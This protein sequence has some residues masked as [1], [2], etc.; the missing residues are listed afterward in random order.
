[1]INQIYEL[2]SQI[3]LGRITTYGRLAK[4][5]GKPKCSRWVGQIMKRNPNPIV[6]PCHRVVLANGCIGE[7][8]FG[9][10]I[11]RN[12]LT[13]EGIIVKNGKIQNFREKL[14]SDFD[15]NNY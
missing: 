10:K 6:I 12:L 2:T 1:M 13:S 15:F 5:L 8:V 11:K 4:A 3:P 9:T 7:Y 14:F